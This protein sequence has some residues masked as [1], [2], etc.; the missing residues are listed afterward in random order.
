[1][2]PVPRRAVVALL[3]GAAF[4][5]P[6]AAGAQLPTIPEDGADVS[7]TPPDPLARQTGLPASSRELPNTGTDPRMLFLGGLALTLMGVGL[8]LRTADADDY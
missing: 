8:R 2:P 1:V 7:P 3:A 5:L 6:A 4:C